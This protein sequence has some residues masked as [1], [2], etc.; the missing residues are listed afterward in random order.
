MP[1]ISE[2]TS[3]I[4]AHA[5]LALQ[6]GFDNAGFQVGDPKA[7]A[8]AALLCLDATEAIVEEAVERQANLIIAHHPLIFHG[9]K[10]LTGASPVERTVAAA[11]RNGITIYSA[12]TNMDSAE[13]GV[14][15]HAAAKI[16]LRNM[17]PLVPHQGKLAKIVTFV[18]TA[19]AQAVK[20]AMWDA[21]AGKMGNYDCCSYSMSGQGTF[22]PAEGAAP[23]VGNIGER[24]T[25]PE[26]R[27]EVITPVWRTHAVLQAMLAKHP[28]EEPA[29]DIIALGNTSSTGLGVVGDIDPE[30]ALHLLR[31]VKEIFEVGAVA[32]SAPDDSPVTVTRVAFCGGSAAEYTPNAIA[33]GAQI[34]I[35]GDVRYH[36]FTENRDRIIVA[37]I[38]HFESEHFTKEIFRDI[39]QKKFPN[40]AAYYAEK[41]KNP[42][43]YL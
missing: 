12:H 18:P 9:I 7:E 28:Y 2:I 22:R 29:Y 39:I 14:S 10:K 42:I 23:Y 6:E 38:G 35:T 33:A 20:Q 13:Y 37:N 26:E 19:Q 40:F 31:R 27:I 3:A 36:N 43:N 30:D 5:P 17:R 15:T 11:I 34:Y 25:E 21:G 16:G 8:T 32:Y 4:E 24:H 41:E 1:R